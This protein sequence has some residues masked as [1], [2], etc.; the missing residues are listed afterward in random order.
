MQIEGG[1]MLRTISCAHADPHKA[2]VT[3]RLRGQRWLRPDAEERSIQ[4]LA[5]HRTTIGFRTYFRATGLT[6]VGL[7]C[8]GRASAQHP[9]DDNGTAAYVARRIDH[10]ERG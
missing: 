10:G 8:T 1:T 9:V 4:M 3:A 6:D 5:R 2:V 7:S